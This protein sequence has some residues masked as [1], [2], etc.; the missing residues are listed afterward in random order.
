[1]VVS[2][3]LLLLLT[4]VEMLLASVTLLQLLLLPSP[5]GALAVPSP[6][7]LVMRTPTASYRTSGCAETV[8]YPS[9][10]PLVLNPWK[11]T[12]SLQCNE[13]MFWESMHAVPVQWS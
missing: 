10:K 2:V 8:L 7:S 5:P 6:P 1:M 11:H 3:T 13:S 9:A 4:V 12:A